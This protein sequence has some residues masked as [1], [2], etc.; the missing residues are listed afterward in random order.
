MNKNATSVSNFG[1]S[2]IKIKLTDDWV[3]SLLKRI[4]YVERKACM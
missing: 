4:G 1:E 3:K 2:G